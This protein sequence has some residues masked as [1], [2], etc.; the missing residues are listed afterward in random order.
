MECA[1]KPIGTS[2]DMCVCVLLK[3]YKMGFGYYTDKII[4][5]SGYTFTQVCIGTILVFHFGE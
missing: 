2:Q 5:F 1:L 3:I 4:N